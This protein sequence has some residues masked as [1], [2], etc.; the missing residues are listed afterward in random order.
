MD[1]SRAWRKEEEAVHDK[2]RMTRPE[3]LGF[4]LRSE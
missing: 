3:E 4:R 2:W 1:I